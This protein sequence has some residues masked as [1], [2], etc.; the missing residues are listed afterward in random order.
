MKIYE[1]EK[2]LLKLDDERSE[3][4]L[5]ISKTLVDNSKELDLILE[6]NE[7]VADLIVKYTE[8]NTKNH[9]FLNKYE[10]LKRELVY[11]INKE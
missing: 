2:E 4:C 10:E 9:E 11:I 3:M 1:I 5:Y 8:L 7:L 6:E